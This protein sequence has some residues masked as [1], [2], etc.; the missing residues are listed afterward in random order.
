MA[1][2]VKNVERFKFIA[3]KI[4]PLVYDDSL[5]YYEFLCKVMQKLN[6]VISS[7]DNQN[8]I[9]EAFDAEILDWETSTDNKY[10]KF[11]NNINTLFEAFKQSEVAARTAFMD[12]LIE[13]YNASTHYAVGQYVRYGNNVYK[14]T[15]ATSGEAW[16]PAH[17]TQVIYANDSSKRQS[18]YE[19]SITAQQNAFETEITGQQNEF[20]S[21]MQAQWNEFF[22]QY[23]QTLNIVQTTGTST[24][25]VMSQKATTTAI[26]EVKESIKGDLGKK[27]NIISNT[28]D[29]TRIYIQTPKNAPTK[30]NTPSAISASKSNIQSDIVPIRGANGNLFV[31][32]DPS[33][34]TDNSAVPKSYVDNKLPNVGGGKIYIHTLNFSF[35][36]ENSYLNLYKDFY[37]TKAEKFTFDEIKQL[38]LYGVSGSLAEN[39]I[40]Q[41]IPIYVSFYNNLLYVYMHTIENS[42]ITQGSWSSSYLL[43]SEH[44]DATNDSTVIIYDR[45]K[46]V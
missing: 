45:V 14:C 1:I 9:L 11:V 38:N 2:N 26:N 13:S 37:S 21:S 40:E 46:E 12:S 15:T 4:I 31:P 16:N 28:T 41:G 7:L 10:N 35:S 36:S 39:G 6:E 33:K 24:T 30:P 20:K 42:G 27:L 44:P 29:L 17:W 18:D 8:E 25:D 23:L 19:E 5:S 3:H 34:L 43:N 32:T 22:N